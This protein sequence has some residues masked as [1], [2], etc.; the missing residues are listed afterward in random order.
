MYWCAYRCGQEE[1]AQ[2]SSENKFITPV[3]MHTLNSSAEEPPDCEQIE[4]FL[5][6]M[7]GFL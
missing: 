5:N 3:L 4:L 2:L 1:L 6:L 7:H